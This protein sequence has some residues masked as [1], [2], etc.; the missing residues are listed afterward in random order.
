MELLIRQWQIHAKHPCDQTWVYEIQTLILNWFLKTAPTAVMWDDFEE[1]DSGKGRKKGEWRREPNLQIIF[2]IKIHM[3]QKPVVQHRTGL[4]FSRYSMNTSL[5]ASFL[6][7]L[8][9]RTEAI[10]LDWNR[11]PDLILSSETEV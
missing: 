9:Q 10:L 5:F 4:Q 2:F 7:I 6:Y 8:P 3:V 1:Q 11:S